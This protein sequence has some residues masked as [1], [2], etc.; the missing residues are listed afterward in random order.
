MNLQELGKNR[1]LMIILVAAIIGGY[2]FIRESRSRLEQRMEKEKPVYLTEA[3]ARTQLGEASAS[4]RKTAH[5]L[6]SDAEMYMESRQYREAAAAYHRAIA[7][8]PDAN[9][10][11]A[12]ARYL[13]RMNKLTMME[14]SL[15]LAAGQGFDRA[16]IDYETARLYGKLNQPYEAFQ[17]LQ[18]AVQSGDFGREEIEEERAFDV[19][20]KSLV[21]RQEYKAFMSNFSY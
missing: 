12:Y 8:Y 9:V 5:Q 13:F 7:I 16:R 10:Y 6:L 3:F 21:T 14:D 15:E 4:D 2:I 19:I 17:Y 18:S 20:R 1:V 11:F